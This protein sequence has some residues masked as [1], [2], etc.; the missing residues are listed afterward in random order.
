MAKLEQ[1]LNGNFNQ[2]LSKI[3]DGIMA[4]CL[5]R[6]RNPVTLEAVMPVAAFEYLKDIVILVATA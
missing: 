6:W 1:T 2:W 5:L 4:V 3:E